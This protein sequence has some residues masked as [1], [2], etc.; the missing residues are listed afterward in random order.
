[1]TNAEVL[2]KDPKIAAELA[3]I[4]PMLAIEED[5][6]K[7]APR[8]PDIASIFAASENGELVPVLDDGNVRPIRWFESKNPPV[9]SYA[10]L[11]PGAHL[12][13]TTLGRLARNLLDERKVY[14]PEVRFSVTSMT[15]T[16]RY[17]RKLVTHPEKLAS[18]TSTHPTGNTFDIDRTGVYTVEDNSVEPSID[19]RRH[20][21]RHYTRPYDARVTRALHTAAVLMHTEGIV[22]L[23]PEKMGTP[24]ACL[25]ISVS[26]HIQDILRD[27]TL[28]TLVKEAVPA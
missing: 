8:F 18:P 13:L 11:T 2:P 14:V 24:W 5:W 23:V 20:P 7:N 10:L 19:P 1:M 12:G 26:P 16:E 17:Q 25:H 4:R 6:H 22:N 28:H 3:R 27:A 15:R 21:G 9:G